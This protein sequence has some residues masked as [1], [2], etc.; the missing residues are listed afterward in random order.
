[1]PGPA[2]SVS[3]QFLV[4][5]PFGL[6]GQPQLQRLA[7]F[8]ETQ[9]HPAFVLEP[10]EENLRRAAGNLVPVDAARM[11]CLSSSQPRSFFALVSRK[12]R[13][14]RSA[15]NFSTSLRL[16]RRPPASTRP[17][18]RSLVKPYASDSKSAESVL[19]DWLNELQ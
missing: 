4:G 3:A 2:S 14:L 18:T 8:V 13:N 1:M 9:Q 15:A 12:P 19:V 6:A 5:E 11:A 17:A 7:Q 10:L 16:A